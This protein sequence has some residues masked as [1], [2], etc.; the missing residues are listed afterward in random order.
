MS[1]IMVV[2]KP[3]DSTFEARLEGEVAGH[4][5]YVTSGTSI[6]LQHTVVDEKFEG[7]GIGG[8]LVR[9]TLDHLR[10]DHLTVIPTCPF[11]KAYIDRHP[12]YQDLV[13]GGR[14]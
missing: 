7:R 13:D 6:D 5:S 9:G 10:A 4:I 12:E 11:V 8:A 2:H 3:T 1:E 14:S